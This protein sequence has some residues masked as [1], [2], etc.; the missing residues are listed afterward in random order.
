MDVHIEAAKVVDEVADDFG[1]AV[2]NGVGLAGAVEL[3]DLA[4]GAQHAFRGAHDHFAAGAGGVVGTVIGDGARGRGD[5]A[6]RRT[7]FVVGE[8][9]RVDGWR[10]HGK[11]TPREHR[12]EMRAVR[13]QRPGAAR[14]A[15]AAGGARC[16]N[17]I[18]PT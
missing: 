5:E 10:D 6:K 18:F 11:G 1:G 3:E 4:G 7:E 16:A 9:D 15:F 2:A 17:G 13:R 8:R 12:H 14:P